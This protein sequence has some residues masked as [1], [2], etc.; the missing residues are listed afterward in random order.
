MSTRHEAT[1]LLT[2]G[3]GLNRLPARAARPYRRGWSRAGFRVNERVEVSAGLEALVLVG[4]T[5]PAWDRE[6]RIGASRD[7]A[8][9]FE[10]E[11]LMGPVAL[12]LAPGIAAGYDF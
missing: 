8:A 4:I 1:C 11:R 3:S 2:S 7:G 9:L 10:A 5:R 12:A 6:H